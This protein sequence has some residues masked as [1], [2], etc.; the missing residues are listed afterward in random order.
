ML[1]PRKRSNEVLKFEQLL[2]SKVVGQEEAVS[3]VVS[4]YQTVLAGMALPARPIANLLFLGPTGSGKTRLVEAIAEILFKNPCAVTKI[5][6]AEFQH[7]HEISKL[8]G[9][10]PGYIGHRET[11]SVFTQGKLEQF[12]NESSK[13]GLVLFDEVE[14]ASNALWQLLLGIMDKATLTL[15][16]NQKVDFSRTIIFMTSNLGAAEMSRLISG[17]IGFAPPL[18]ASRAGEIDRGVSSVAIEAANRRFPPEFMNRLD[19]VV[20]FRPLGASELRQI[21]DLEL[22]NVQGRI[23]SL[24]PSQRFHLHFTGKAKTFLLHEGT[25]M[26]YGAR[27]LKRAIEHYL[28]VPL[29]NLIMTNQVSPGESIQVGLAGGKLSFTKMQVAAQLAGSATTW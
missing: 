2:R 17:A 18:T 3:Q 21:L 24:D 5:D 7:S 29:A 9:S 23:M 25:D 19:N 8:I 10:P 12:Y 28:V 15:G 26:K 27:Y 22:D 20:V 6:C 1:D 13:F 14:K 4:I 16:D 11:H